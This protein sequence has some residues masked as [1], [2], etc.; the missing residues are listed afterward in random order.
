MELTEIYSPL[1]APHVKGRYSKLEVDP[2][3]HEREPQRVGQQPVAVASG[4]HDHGFIWE[5]DQRLSQ[6][7]YCFVRTHGF[8]LRATSER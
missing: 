3:T 6:I 7:G 5:A 8:P 4:E 2:E 1:W